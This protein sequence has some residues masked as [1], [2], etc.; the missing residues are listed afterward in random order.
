MERACF[1]FEIY[2]GK[3]DEYKRRHDE[4][5]PDMVAAISDAGLRNYTLFRR[6]THV[7]GYVECHP[8]VETAFGKIAASD[9]NARWAEWFQDVIASLTDENG[10]LRF[11]NEVW[12]LD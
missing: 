11:H 7:V 5:W 9:V 1:T 3:E 8:D 4:I 6:G 10:E 2:P 12:H